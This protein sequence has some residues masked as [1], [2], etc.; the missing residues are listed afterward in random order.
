VPVFVCCFLGL[1]Y[2]TVGLPFPEVLLTTISGNCELVSVG[3]PGQV[4]AV[5][6]MS[7]LLVLFLFFVGLD[8]H[9]GHISD[10]N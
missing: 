5:L 6:S 2:G 7:C 3:F 10:L 8:L 9:A 4:F 1:W